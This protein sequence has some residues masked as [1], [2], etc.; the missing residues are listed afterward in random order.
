[1]SIEGIHL[2][3]QI[4]RVAAIRL[5]QGDHHDDTSN[6]IRYE[7]G[8]RTALVEDSHPPIIFAKGR[9]NAKTPIREDERFMKLRCQC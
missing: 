5:K 6:A 3:E 2:A 9:L 8:N 1:M 7:S 4:R